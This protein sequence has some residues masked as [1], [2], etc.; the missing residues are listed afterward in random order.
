MK[1]TELAFTVLPVRDVK[2]AREFYTA[3]LGLKETANW[4]DKW[5]E[6]D[7]GPGTLAITDG[8]EQLTPGAKGAMVAI[9]VEDL[10]TALRELEAKQVKLGMAPFDTP[11]CSG[12]TLLD[13]DGN[14]VMLHQRKR[15]G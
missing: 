15:A 4:Q 12:A 14:E 10:P 5:I 2:R 9:E 1:M 7:I 3:T 8:F 6:F 11:V 13:P